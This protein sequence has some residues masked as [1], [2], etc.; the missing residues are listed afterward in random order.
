MADYY[1]QW[2]NWYDILFGNEDGLH[3]FKAEKFSIQK[4]LWPGNGK[5]GLS[6]NL[7]SRMGQLV[8][9]CGWKTIPPVFNHCT[10][11]LSAENE[12]RALDL[13]WHVCCNSANME[14]KQIET[15]LKS[16]VELNPFFSEPHILLAEL[17]VQKAQFE[18]AESEA[19]EGLR[20]LTL[21][22]SV[23]DKRISWEG[24]IAWA[25]V[26]LSNAKQKT[27]PDNAW[28]IVGLGL[29]K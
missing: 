5:P 25:R 29:V 10:E 11:I 8:R 18:N 17:Y 23:A 24:W 27:W 21:W 6:M 1:D 20:L 16:C 9:K 7:I 14:Y 26:L 2:Y 3:S 22:G 4:V 12:I 28:G 19:L 15:S 13:Y